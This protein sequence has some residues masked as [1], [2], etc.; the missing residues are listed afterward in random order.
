M[1]FLENEFLSTNVTCYSMVQ[2]TTLSSP[3]YNK[4]VVHWTK[5]NWVVRILIMRSVTDFNN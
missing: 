5:R 1:M 3:R 4:G 2:G